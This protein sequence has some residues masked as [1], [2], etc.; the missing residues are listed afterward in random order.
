MHHRTEPSFFL[1]K[2]TGEAQL[3]LDGLTTPISI[4]SLRYFPSSPSKPYGV[5]LKGWRIGLAPPVSILWVIIEQVPKSNLFLAEASLFCNKTYLCL[6]LMSFSELFSY[7]STR[8]SGNLGISANSLSLPTSSLH[9]RQ[10]QSSGI[11]GIHVSAL[12]K[13]IDLISGLV[14]LKVGSENSSLEKCSMW[15][16]GCNSPSKYFFL[17]LTENLS[18]LTNL[19]GIVSL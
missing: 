14:K 19:I 11:N 1:I 18:K 10:F 3:D 16:T 13:S 6:W 17:I 12:L 15:V 8:W 4:W 7:R 5:L 9:S 2:Q